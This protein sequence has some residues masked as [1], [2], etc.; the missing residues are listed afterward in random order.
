MGLLSVPGAVGCGGVKV[1][2]STDVVPFCS[3]SAA[4]SRGAGIDPKILAIKALF[5]PY[6]GLIPEILP[7]S[8]LIRAL[9][10][11]RLA[12]S[13]LIRSLFRP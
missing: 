3:V 7:Y 11:E 4:K 13:A 1:V 8:A 9:I 5:G 2:V 10:P 6:S 12:Y